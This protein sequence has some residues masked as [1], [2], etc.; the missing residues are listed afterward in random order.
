MDVTNEL[1]QSERDAVPRPA[2]GAAPAPSEATGVIDRYNFLRDSDKQDMMTF[3][4]SL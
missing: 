3:L 1:F 2:A 4:R